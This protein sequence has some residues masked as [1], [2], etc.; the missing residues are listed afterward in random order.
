MPSPTPRL[1]VNDERSL[2]IDYGE[3][4]AEVVVAVGDKEPVWDDR[5]CPLHAG[6]HPRRG[7]GVKYLVLETIVIPERLRE[8]SVESDAAREVR[9]P[10]R[11]SASF[12]AMAVPH[13]LLSVVLGPLVGAVA[14]D[15]VGIWW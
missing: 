4:I 1:R 13:H 7:A 10:A 12:G 9:K 6:H 5:P 2:G 14:T 15:L 11:I 8:C 3:Q